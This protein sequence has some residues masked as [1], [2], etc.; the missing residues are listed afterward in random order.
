VLELIQRPESAQTRFLDQV[1]SVRGLT[2]QAKRRPV[3][4][5]AVYE[6]V[7]FEPSDPVTVAVGAHVST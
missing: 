4:V 2:R 6:H 1:L 3:Q 5:I 7:V